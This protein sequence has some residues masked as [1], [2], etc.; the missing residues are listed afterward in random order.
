MKQTLDTIKTIVEQETL[1]KSDSTV[2]TKITY[3]LA[4]KND[5]LIVLEYFKV[6]IWPSIAIIA[7]FCFRKKLL[8]LLDRIIKESEELS[9][10]LLGLNA[11]FRKDIAK[12]EREDK[13]SEDYKDK[14]DNVVQKNLK[15]EFRLLAS[16][17]FTK[18]IEIRQ[19]TAIEISKLS[20]SMSIEQLLN[21]AASS[22]PGERV[23]AYIGITTHLRLF[24]DLEKQESI[25]DIIQQGLDDGLS[26][27]RYRV[28]EAINCSSYLVD[29]FRNNL[30]ELYQEEKNKPVKKLLEKVLN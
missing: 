28:I 11:K 5:S 21:F 1:V 17:F 9:S 2:I 22:S 25:I 24:P 19:K 13:N 29:L 15:D 20:Q 23:A 12:V 18:S 6:L 7:I 10:S 26:R 16:Y 8:E 3:E 4:E 27:V 14:I 30:I